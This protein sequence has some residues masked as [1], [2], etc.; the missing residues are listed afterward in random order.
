V[1]RVRPAFKL[2]SIR[3]YERKV[4]FVLGALHLNDTMLLHLPAEPFVEY[5]LRAQALRP[6]RPVAVAAYGDCGPWYIPTRAEY[7]AGGYEVEHAFFDASAED[8]LMGAIA[9]LGA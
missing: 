8:L 5:Q 1:A 3:R 7:P 9:R 4:P 2:A 6:R